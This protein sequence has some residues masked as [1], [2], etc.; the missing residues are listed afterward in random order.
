MCCKILRIND[1]EIQKEPNVWCSNWSKKTKCSIY[2]NRPKVCAGFE[3]LWL[4][5]P[6][7]P[8]EIRPDKSGAV[9]KML[10]SGKLVVI[11]DKQR[12][13]AWREGLLGALLEAYEE[14][15][16]IYIGDQKIAEVHPIHE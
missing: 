13:N 6:I 5:D 10:D 3:C 4:K 16:S 12:P 8:E 9:L 14:G 1:S 7:L 15:Y 2:E 11:V